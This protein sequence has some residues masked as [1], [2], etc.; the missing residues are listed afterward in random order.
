MR[1][2]LDGHPTR[3][4]GTEYSARHPRHRGIQPSSSGGQVVCWAF[5]TNRLRSETGT[6][7]AVHVYEVTTLSATDED[8]PTPEAF[9]QLHAAPES[10]FGAK[11]P[12]M[13]IR[14]TVANRGCAGFRG[15]T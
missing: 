12:S 13:D 9:W 5:V 7:F 6:V 2:T 11:L 10:V 14:W 1:P 15:M 8:L 4:V 3:T